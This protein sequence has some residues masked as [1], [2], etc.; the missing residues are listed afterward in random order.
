MVWQVSVTLPAYV[1]KFDGETRLPIEAT[2]HH[3]K[4]SSGTCAI[5]HTSVCST[6]HAEAHAGNS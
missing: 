1:A 5:A 4:R 2:S 3:T 6:R